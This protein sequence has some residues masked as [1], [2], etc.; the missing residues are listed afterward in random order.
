M[1]YF[2]VTAEDLETGKPHCVTETG[3]PLEISLGAKEELDQE[4]YITVLGARL[5][6]NEEGKKR[7]DAWLNQHC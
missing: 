7:Y 2:V 6:L 4:G 5:Y 1:S 3:C